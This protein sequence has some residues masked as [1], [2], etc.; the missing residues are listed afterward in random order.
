MEKLIMHYKVL[1]AQARISRK[2]SRI[3]E[4][5]VINEWWVTPIPA[6]DGKIPKEADLED[7]EKVV[8]SYFDMSYS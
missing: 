2:L 7:I 5:E 6:L 3:M 4:D 8:E 1:Y